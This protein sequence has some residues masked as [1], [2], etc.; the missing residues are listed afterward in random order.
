MSG[1]AIGRYRINGNVVEP[2]S[3]QV[4]MRFEADEKWVYAGGRLIA[5][6]LASGSFEAVLTDRVGSVRVQGTTSMSYFPFGR[7]R[8]SSG[9]GNRFGTYYRDS[10]GL[11]YANQRY[12]ASQFG[13]FMTADPYIGSA[14]LMRSLSWNRYVYVEGDPINL[15]DPSGLNLAKTECGTSGGFGW[16]AAMTGFDS[17]CGGGGGGFL[18]AE[19]GLGQTHDPY[20]GL[21][22]EMRGS[23]LR[24]DGRVQNTIDTKAAQAALDN[25]DMSTAEQIAMNNPAVEF[26]TDYPGYQEPKKGLARA[27]L[28]PYVTITT[29]EPDEFGKPTVSGIVN[30]P[31]AVANILSGPDFNKGRMCGMHPAVGSRCF[32]YRSNLDVFGPGSLQVV[33]GPTRF[34]ADVDRFN[35]YNPIGFVLHGVFEFIAPRVGKFMGAR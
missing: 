31:G 12:Y 7:E 23:A 4:V 9:A 27:G 33:I 10:G 15:N 16:G 11:D 35:A 28:L 13:R 22:P 14:N 5:R 29:T 30:Q 1:K 24:F 3:G 19:Y 18:S 34:Y 20:A 25:G 8:T 26:V 17:V 32:D 21:S 6:G 2:G